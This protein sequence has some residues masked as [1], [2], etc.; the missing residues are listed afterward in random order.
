M[1]CPE[2]SSNVKRGKDG[3]RCRCGYAFIIDPKIYTRMTDGKFLAL[4][5]Q[6]GRN[7]TYYFTA[8]QLWNRYC[9]SYG[10]GCIPAILLATVIWCL[11]IAFLMSAEGRGASNIWTPRSFMIMLAMPVVLTLIAMPLRFRTLPPGGRRRFDDMLSLW[12]SSHPIEKLLTK[13]SL[14]Q[15]P[16]DWAEKDIYDYGVE[17]IL[18]V[19][20]D[21][22]VDSFVLNG[23]YAQAR[24]L[25]L[26]VSGYPSYLAPRANRILQE[27]PDTPVFLLHDATPEGMGLEPRLRAAAWLD[28]KNITVVDLG[29][30]PSDIKRIRGLRHL[31]PAKDEYRLPLDMIAYP[32]LAAGMVDALA[33]GVPLGEL[34]ERPETQDGGGSDG[35]FG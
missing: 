17:K 16:P 11:F 32:M 22:Y 24:A 1:K 33:L 25:I 27:H 28:L 30:T 12:Q 19:D 15:P 13:P 26:S 18:I 31:K 29:L 14:H 21:L 6:A 5:R 34:I 3:M 20:Q 4:I 7:G 2:C 8:N 9:K 35:G 23:F 10:M